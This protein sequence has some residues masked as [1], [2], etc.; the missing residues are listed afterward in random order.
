ME[1]PRVVNRLILDFLADDRTPKMFP[2][3]D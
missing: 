2:L 1:K 3:V